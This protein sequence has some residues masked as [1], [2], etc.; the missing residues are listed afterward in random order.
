MLRD[1]TIHRSN[2]KSFLILTEYID[3]TTNTYGTDKTT[4]YNSSLA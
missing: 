4:L 1:S 3:I 2:F